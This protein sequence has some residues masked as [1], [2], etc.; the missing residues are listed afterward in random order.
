MP[1]PYIRIDTCPC[2]E[3]MAGWTSEIPVVVA[4]H[5]S[6]VGGLREAGIARFPVGADL[7]VRPWWGRSW[8]CRGDGMPR[9]S[10]GEPIMSAFADAP[11]TVEAQAQRVLHLGINRDGG[12]RRRVSVALRA[13]HASPLVS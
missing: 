4:T 1:G 10:G 2:C 9:P 11:T 8:E 3:R 7:C 13:R 12:Q 5:A 6:R